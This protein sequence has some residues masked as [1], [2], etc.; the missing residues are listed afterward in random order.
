MGVRDRYTGGAHSGSAA[1]YNTRS[2]GQTFTAKY[3]YTMTSVELELY[4]DTSNVVTLDINIYATTAGLPTG[5]SL[6]SGS[7]STADIEL[8][9]G[10][11]ELHSIVLSAGVVLQKGTMYAICGTSSTANSSD[12]KWVT[13]TG[14]GFTGGTR[15]YDSSPGGAWTGTIAHDMNF[16][17]IATC[18]AAEMVIGGSRNSDGSSVWGMKADGT[19]VWTYDTG[20]K[21]NKVRV[22]ASG[23]YLVVGVRAR[24]VEGQAD[25]LSQVW[26]LND[27]GE[28]QLRADL[29]AT[30]TEMRDAKESGSNLFF[31]GAGGSCR[32]ALDLTG[33]AWIRQT[34]SQ[35][36]V[37]VYSGDGSIY[38][39]SGGAGNTMYKYNSSL[40][41]QWAEDTNDTARSLDLLSTGEIVM[42]TSDGEIRLYQADGSSPSAG[43]W[44]YVM[45]V[46]GAYC[47]CIVDANDVI[48]GALYDWDLGDTE[49]IVALNTSGVRQ[50]GSGNMQGNIDSLNLGGADTLYALRTATY[51]P[52]NILRIDTSGQ[53]LEGIATVPYYAA[54]EL[55]M[56]FAVESGF[57]Y[58]EDLTQDLEGFW[59]MN[60]DA[61]DTVVADSSGN[62]RDGVATKNTSVMNTTGKINDALAFVSGDSDKIALGDISAFDI[63]PYQDLTLAF[64]SNWDGSGTPG[65]D[66]VVL[67]KYEDPGTPVGFTINIFTTTDDAQVSMFFP[68][69]FSINNTSAIGGDTMVGWHLWVVRI[70][71]TGNLSLSIDNAE[72]YSIEDIQVRSAL[73][74]SNSTSLTV[75]EGWDVG[76]GQEYFQGD[77]DAVG[78]WSRLL[79]EVEEAELWNGGSG[80]EGFVQSAPT[81]SDQSTSATIAVDDA[82]VLSVTAT[83]NPVPTYQWDKDGTPLGGETSSTLSFT[84]TGSSG[85]VYNC[86]VTNVVGSVSTTDITLSMVPTIS[87]QS[88]DT[89]ALAGQLTTLTVTALG[90]PALTYQWYKDDVEVAGATAASYQFYAAASYAGTYKCTVTNGVG[91]VDSADIVLTIGANPYSR[92]FFNQY[93]DADRINGGT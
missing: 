52:N 7:I 63:G 27:V 38:V 88:S 41:Y 68:D 67:H 1:I 39:G 9:V 90:Y 49:R 76:G 13:D 40:V 42:G 44:A 36:S 14:G 71:R 82:V 54:P 72:H 75:A 83:G 8:G 66:Q 45:Y 46:A 47:R 32:T 50:W 60:D 86:T 48:Y 33:F 55:E 89:A 2:E 18:D 4:R 43:T 5:P 58:T 81:I 69:A 57:T 19:E 62:S 6:A 64:W 24:A 78:I 22:L 11:S 56:H 87:A 73:D 85:G 10:D 92:N 16:Q 79:S 37:A 59:N 70:D 23:D 20:G 84:A 53:T 77:I 93:I 15:I 61:G 35:Y 51:Y 34:T 21:V 65:T 74:L 3:S 30:L 31:A 17:C 12:I 25:D 80:T 29:D 28:L 26:I 91:S